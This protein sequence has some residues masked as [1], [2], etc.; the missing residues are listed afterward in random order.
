ML[1][2]STATFITVLFGYVVMACVLLWFFKGRISQSNALTLFAVVVSTLIAF[3]LEGGNTYV[4]MASA[5]IPS[6]VALTLTEIGNE[7]SD[8]KVKYQYFN[9][10]VNFNVFFSLLFAVVVGVLYM[11]GYTPIGLTIL[12]GMVMLSVYP[13]IADK[14]SSIRNLMSLSEGKALDD[15]LY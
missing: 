14:P 2:L 7:C 5:L 12:A 11:N 8:E 10:A 6:A 1:T 4:V 9:M 3:V 13:S 15:L